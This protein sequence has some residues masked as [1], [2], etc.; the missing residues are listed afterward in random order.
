MVLEIIKIAED[1][2]DRLKARRVGELLDQGKL[3]IV[4]TE[5]VYGI[6]FDVR[7]AAARQ[8][9]RELRKIAGNPGWVIHLSAPS[10][11]NRYVTNI[12][13]VARRIVRKAWPGPVALQFPFAEDDLNR[14]NE[15]LGPASGEVAQDGWWTFRC[16][17]SI[18]TQQILAGARVPVVI[19]GARGDA[20]HPADDI[21]TLA[22]EIAAGV[23]VLV[24]GG[25][26]RYRK[27]ST[28]V[29]LDGSGPVLLREGVIDGRLIERMGNMTGLFLCSGNTCRSPMAAGIAARLVAE[30]KGIAV[31][32]LRQRG[33]VIQSAGLHTMG[34]SRATNEAVAAAGELGAD[35]SKHISQGISNELLRRA[36]AIYTMTVE[37]RDELIE[38]FPAVSEK[39][40]RLDADADIEDPAGESIERYR[41]VARRLEFAIGR[42]L[43]G[44]EL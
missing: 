36:D 8:R 33:I 18:H 39:T 23:D 1:G 35:I 15:L 42:R 28:L 41:Q 6:A 30:Q 4:P 37:L 11:L 21:A 43:Q 12:S 3:V 13:P 17:E 25:H 34:G 40:F 10:D 19:V 22:E 7:N 32:E 27:A 24:D 16:P 26:V 44:L 31:D 29:R 5:T 2:S 14:L 38:R 20:E 9:V